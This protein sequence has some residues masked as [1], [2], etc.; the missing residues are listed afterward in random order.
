MSSPNHSHPN[1]WERVI[2]PLFIDADRQNFPV[3]PAGLSLPTSNFLALFVSGAFLAD[4]ALACL[5][6]LSTMSL[7]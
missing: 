1:K 3:Y 4:K 5:K 7:R 2:C 6:S